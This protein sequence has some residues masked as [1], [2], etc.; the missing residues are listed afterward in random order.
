ML[1]RYIPIEEKGFLNHGILT[2]IEA[3]ESFLSEN[4]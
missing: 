3:S 1:G 4:S 2:S